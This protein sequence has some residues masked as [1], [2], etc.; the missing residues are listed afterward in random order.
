MAVYVDNSY[1]GD[2]RVVISW[3][4]FAW[5]IAEARCILVTRICVPICVFVC[6]CLAAFPHYCMD[7]DVTWGNRRACPLVVHYWADLQ[8]VCTVRV[9]LLCNVVPN[10]KCQR[11]LCTRCNSTRSVSVCDYWL[12]CGCCAVTKP[13]VTMLSLVSWN[14]LTV[15]HRLVVVRKDSDEDPLPKHSRERSSKRKS[16]RM[17][18]AGLAE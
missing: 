16:R 9:S 17:D 13:V 2:C 18:V 7:R 3:L 4:H 15:W 5:G 12:S 14:V 10:V 8:S 1:G 6:L 11:V